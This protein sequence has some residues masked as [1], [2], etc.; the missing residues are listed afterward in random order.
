MKLKICGI[1]NQEMLTFCEKQKVDYLGFN[2]VSWSK[3][4]LTNFELLKQKI[5][6]Q[7]VALFMNQN[8]D[9]VFEILKN[10]DFE[11]VQFHGNE[12]A[13]YLQKVKKAFSKV[14]ICKAFLVDENFKTNQ[15]ENYLKVC[16]IFLFDGQNPGS[17][18]NIFDLSMLQEL[19]EF[20][21]KKKI[22]YGIAGGINKKNI[23]K[24]KK[25][26]PKAL[27]LDTASGVEKNKKFD[28]NTAQKLIDNLKK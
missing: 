27:F 8:F 14:R 19:I 5:S 15:L 9:E 1:R 21:E 26:F 3:R 6:A 12:T 16:D 22:S 4:K 7:K 11:V 17:G 2:F 10:F 13:K 20:S 24:F 23:T 28:I 18:Q 25:D